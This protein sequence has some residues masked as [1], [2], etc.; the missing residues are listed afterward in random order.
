MRYM[1]GKMRIGKQLANVIQAYQPTAYDE[2]FCGVFSVGKH[3]ICNKRT[4]GDIQ[5][6]LILLLKAIQSGWDPPTNI[7]EEQYDA[8]RNTPPSALRGFVGFGCS[9]YGKFF[10]GFARDPSM[11]DFGTIARNNLLKLAPLIQ[12]VAFRNEHYLD[13][14]GNAD[15]IYCDPPYA[16]ATDYDCGPFDHAQFWDWVRNRKELVLVSEYTAPDDFEIIWQKP[17]TTTMKD[18]TGHGCA[19]VERLFCHKRHHRIGHVA[20]LADAR[21]S[22]TRGE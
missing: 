6:D 18:R 7:T 15:V 16:G 22:R 13:Y 19:R 20:E 4:A 5:P 11:N 10:G 2:P 21:V 8:L 14:N 9:F 17:V 3:I 1:G 12:D